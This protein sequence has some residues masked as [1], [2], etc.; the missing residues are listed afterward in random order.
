MG[1]KLKA[2]V[3]LGNPGPQYAGTKHNAGFMV[4]DQVVE[5]VSEIKTEA[6]RYESQFYQVRYASSDLLL[7]KPLTYMNLSGRATAKIARIFKLKPQEVL[8]VYDCMDLPLGR[9]RL[10]PS[11]SSGGH[12]GMESI[13]QAFESQEVPRL[14]VG[15]GRS[16]KSDSVEHVLS[17]YSGPENE[18]MAKVL[19]EAVKAV[20][21]AVRGG[22]VK[23][24]NKYNALRLDSGRGD[25]PIQNQ[26]HGE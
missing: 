12:K 25:D 11:G 21:L 8:V 15:I 1:N 20:L 2:V 24:M 18:I 26:A 3:G 9:L 5:K 23:A 14:R 19:N 13:I 22:V 10:R 16:E 6:H 7:V 17:E 4:V